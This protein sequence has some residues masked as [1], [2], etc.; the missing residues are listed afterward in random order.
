MSKRIFSNNREVF[1]TVQVQIHSGNGSS[2][3]I[4]LLP[5]HFH[6]LP[7]LSLIT[8]VVQTLDEHTARAASW[9]IYTFIGLWLK[10]LGHQRNH[11][12]VGIEFL[13]CIAR[14]ISKLANQVLISLAHF[15]GGT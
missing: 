5:E 14:I 6:A 4:N 3:R 11:C 8:Q 1:H 12:P 2:Q 15:I 10:N 7:G 9:I 13:S